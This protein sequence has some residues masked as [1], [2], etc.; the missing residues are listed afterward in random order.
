[1]AN[2][3]RVVWVLKLLAKTKFVDY[4]DGISCYYDNLIN[5]TVILYLVAVISVRHITLRYAD[6]AFCV[7][8]SCR[9]SC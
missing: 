3:F 6:L 7:C 9:N 5:R 2:P 8:C 1:M 4:F